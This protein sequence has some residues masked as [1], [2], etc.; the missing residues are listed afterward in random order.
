MY[1]HKV[2]SHASRS[3]RLAHYSFDMNSRHASGDAVMVSV[4]IM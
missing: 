4:K 1:S 2:Y 3:V